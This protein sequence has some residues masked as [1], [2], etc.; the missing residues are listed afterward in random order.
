MNPEQ[1]RETDPSQETSVKVDLAKVGE[2]ALEKLRSLEM[3]IEKLEKEKQ[4]IE[5][6][7][8]AVDVQ[9]ESEEYQ[10]DI[11]RLENI[12]NSLLEYKKEEEVIRGIFEL[13][14]PQSEIG[15]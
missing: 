12:N 2:V 5:D 3:M 8:N 4:E 10:K 14:I 11:E 7:M 13:V 6:R 1:P 15:A 9:E